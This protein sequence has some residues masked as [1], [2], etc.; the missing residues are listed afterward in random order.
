MTK[1]RAEPQEEAAAARVPATT[2]QLPSNE[3]PERRGLSGRLASKP[4]SREE[5]E[6]RYVAARDAWTQ[7]MR[8]ASSGR[9]A[10]LASLALAQEAYEEAS[11]ERERWAKDT[12]RVAIPIEPESRK[13]LDAAV[14]QELRWREV[15]APHE[16]RG[17]LGR[18]KRRIGR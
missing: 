12:G 5:A 2:P 6:A 4:R 18:L 17:L 14:G 8:A 1:R 13:G 15:R 3:P 7:A 11:H 9:P 10:D 16:E